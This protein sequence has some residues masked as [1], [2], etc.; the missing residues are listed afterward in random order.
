MAM[1]N[2]VIG[3]DG[4]PSPADYMPIPVGTM[5][6]PASDIDPSWT[7]DGV[8]GYD[9]HHINM[10]QA[11]YVDGWVTDVDPGI[12]PNHAVGGQPGRV[13]VGISGQMVVGNTDGTNVAVDKPAV[14]T[15][16]RHDLEGFTG[17]VGTADGRAD[18]VTSVTAG[19][20]SSAGVIPTDDQMT[21]MII[22]M[23]APD[24][25]QY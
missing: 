22:T 19:V 25:V 13:P 17:P 5:F 16:W 7:V 4:D 24:Y 1:P 20:A 2:D 9:E 14:H 6:G 21:A 10:G 3:Q 18:L 8:H 11:S 23:Q 12:I 15:Y